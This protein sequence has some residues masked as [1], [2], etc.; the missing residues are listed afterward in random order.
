MTGQLFQQNE[1]TAAHARVFLRL[2]SST[3]GVSALTG[4]TGTGMVSK[5]GAAPAATTN[6]LVEVD[7]TNMPG[8]YYITLTA[9]EL[10]TLG[11]VAVRYKSAGSLEAIG[12]GAVVPFDPYAT[13]KTGFSLSSVGN[14]AIR[15]T[16][17]SDSTPFAGANVAAIKAKTDNLPAA[18]AAVSDIPTANIT[19]IKAKTDNLPAAP[20]AVSDIPTANIAAIKAK[21]DNLP[22]APAAVSDIPTANITAIKAKTDNLPSV[23]AGASGGL[24]TVDAA[25]AVKV[26]AGTGANQIDLAAGKVKLDSTGM[27]LIPGFYPAGNAP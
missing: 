15:D 16:I 5:A 22:A 23:A 26:Q 7:A 4:Q 12:F 14:N 8:L 11:A 1:A 3:D 2:I 20:A 9:T 24:P 21:T 18:P 6:S 25:N 19:A 17:L 10:D 13:D 27:N